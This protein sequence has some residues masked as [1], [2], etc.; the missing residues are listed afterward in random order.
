[1]ATDGVTHIPPSPDRF[2][3]DDERIAFVRQRIQI[4]GDDYVPYLRMAI[5]FGIDGGTDEVLE[6]RFVSF[7]DY[8]KTTSMDS[9]RSLA[10]ETG[11][12]FQVILAED[13]NIMFGGVAH[14]QV[15][16]AG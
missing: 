11:L 13:V 5:R 3:T 2:N 7:F 9:M 6:E 12:P 1:M 15:A 4:D 14:N 8:L 10:T 16:P